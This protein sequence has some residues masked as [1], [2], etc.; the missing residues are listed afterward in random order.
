MMKVAG[1]P[2]GAHIRAA[3]GPQLLPAQQK[4]HGGLKACGQSI[5]PAAALHHL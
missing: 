4:V 5:H 3:P 2:C 1:S